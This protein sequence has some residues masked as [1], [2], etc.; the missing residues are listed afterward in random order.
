MSTGNRVEDARL[1]FEKLNRYMNG[2]AAFAVGCA[3]VTA[4]LIVVSSAFPRVGWQLL[5]AASVFLV[6]TIALA[7]SMGG[8]LLLGGYQ[9]ATGKWTT[10]KLAETDGQ[11]KEEL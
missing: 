5:E 3:V 4:V 1:A 11:D 6:L 10:G 9:K 8:V 2:A 7:V